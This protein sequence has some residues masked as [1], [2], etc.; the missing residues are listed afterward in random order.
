MAKP[1]AAKWLGELQM[2]L[3]GTS[4]M[5][6]GFVVATL[7]QGVVT[8]LIAFSLVI[9]GATSCTPILNGLTSKRNV[10]AVIGQVMGS[11]SAM[12][13]WGR[14]ASPLVAGLVLMQLGFS[15]AWMVGILY[16]TVMLFWVIS[17]L[18]AR[19]ATDAE[20]AAY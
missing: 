1:N 17:E 13:A 12:S 10:P 2:L 20:A 11:A 6:S 8:M 18:K 19:A 4:M 7:S 5:L 15:V 16:S 9:T 3:I 14:S